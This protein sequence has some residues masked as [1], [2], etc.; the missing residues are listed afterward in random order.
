MKEYRDVHAFLKDSGDQLLQSGVVQSTN[1]QNTGTL[2]DQLRELPHQFFAISS[3]TATLF[4]AKGFQTVPWWFV[5]EVLTEFLNLNPPLMTRYRADLIDQSYKVMPDG[6]VEYMYGSRWKEHNQ[7]HNV[8]QRL[9]GNPNSKRAIIQT[10]MPYDSEPGRSDVPCNTNYMFLGRNGVLDMTATIRSNDI[11]RGTKYDYPLAG[12][13]H[14]VV[15]GLTGQKPGKLVFHVNSLHVY[16]KDIDKLREAVKEI[17]PTSARL[18]LPYVMDDAT[19]WRDLRGVKAVEE[20][21]YNG[22]FEYT[23]THLSRIYYP[24]FRDFGRIIAA[25]NAKHSKRDDVAGRLESQL[26]D[27]DIRGWVLK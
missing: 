4:N 14:Q 25:R 20:A 13:M 17:T 15:S 9:R 27:A 10:W 24:V 26:E 8:V 2:K 16:E 11:L 7:I 12:F 19:L 21:S 22:S 5:G 18:T 23:D 3:P 1:V 6:T